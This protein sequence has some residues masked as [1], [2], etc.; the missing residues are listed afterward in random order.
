MKCQTCG[1]ITDPTKDLCGR[2]FADL[3]EQKK[4]LGLPVLDSTSSYQEL[5]AKRVKIVENKQ[6]KAKKSD[7]KGVLGLFAKKPATPAV[8]DYSTEDHT[9]KVTEDSALLTETVISDMEPALAPES[10]KLSA[11]PQKLRLSKR[12]KGQMLGLLRARQEEKQDLEEKKK[13]EDQQKLSY[14]NRL[15]RLKVVPVEIEQ[16]EAQM[17]N[18]NFRELANISGNI[19][20]NTAIGVTSL[21]SKDSQAATMVYFDLAFEEL[22]SPQNKREFIKQLG[23][24][25]IDSIESQELKAA[26]GRFQKD[27]LRAQQSGA[28]VR[29]Q[30]D[31]EVSGESAKTGIRLL[32]WFLDFSSAI[33]LSLIAA[34]GLY[35]S[36]YP[37][38]SEVLIGEN[39]LQLSDL[40]TLLILAVPVFYLIILILYPLSR[41][42]FGRT[43]GE[44]LTRLKLFSTDSERLSLR[45][46]IAWNLLSILALISLGFLEFRKG[47]DLWREKILGARLLRT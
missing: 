46:S 23:E 44:F 21:L 40:L 9:A 36:N 1:F 17:W 47:P 20:K 35:L 11:E 14:Q 25:R 33:S 19:S 28:E 34:L 10:A 7:K 22:S 27:S 8:T 43:V 41:V 24:N 31:L 45:Q 4:E 42:V 6:D 37:V 12:Q 29:S 3:R 32:S 39:E 38:A 16:E 26:I 30:S 5:L 15:A 18:E 2:C 13:I